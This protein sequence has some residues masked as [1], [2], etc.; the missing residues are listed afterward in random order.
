MN[1]PCSSAEGIFLITDP[2][3][4]RWKRMLEQCSPLSFYFSVLQVWRF[5]G[6]LHRAVSPDE[7][8]IDPPISLLARADEMIE[9]WPSESCIMQARLRELCLR[10]GAASRD[11]SKA[12]VTA[13]RRRRP[14][15]IS[16]V[17]LVL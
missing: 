12:S 14:S 9:N 3:A 6:R 1:V 13:H 15:H 16:G 17:P 2:R 11:V 4:D 7:S 5:T 10:E 8:P